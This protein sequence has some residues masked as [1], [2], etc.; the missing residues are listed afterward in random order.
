MVSK[1]IDIT[2][3]SAVSS[4]DTERLQPQP[5]VDSFLETL[6]KILA[7]DSQ[8]KA[9]ATAFDAG[10]K[11]VQIPENRQL[12]LVTTEVV[13][14]K[15]TTLMGS[16][17]NETP[18]IPDQ[19]DLFAEEFGGFLAQIGEIYKANSE[20]YNEP[21]PP[22]VGHAIVLE[23]LFCFYVSGQTL[24][25]NTYRSFAVMYGDCS[26]TVEK[27]FELK[28][29][30]VLTAQSLKHCAEVASMVDRTVSKFS[31][32]AVALHAVLFVLNQF[33]AHLRKSLDQGLLGARDCT[34]QCDIVTNTVYNLFSMSVKTLVESETAVIQQGLKVTQNPQDDALISCRDGSSVHGIREKEDKPMNVL[35]VLHIKNDAMDL[36]DSVETDPP[37]GTLKILH[38]PWHMWTHAPHLICQRRPS[39]VL[40][41]IVL[42]E[43]RTTDLS[44]LTESGSTSI[45]PA[46]DLRVDNATASSSKANRTVCA[47]PGTLL[48]AGEKP[49]GC[50]HK[51]TSTSKATQLAP[52]IVCITELLKLEK[53]VAPTASAT[54]D[55][56]AMNEPNSS[57][58]TPMILTESEYTTGC[59][60]GPQNQQE[61]RKKRRIKDCRLR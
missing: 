54:D 30:D 33:P 40:Q 20:I 2:T 7:V 23:R 31:K 41:K 57:A 1:N 10:V 24:F 9:T 52:N 34:A 36:N 49:D 22:T 5:T 37:T 58:T 39:S 55:V 32:D 3:P 44:K 12:M 29:Q 25:E 43:I 42:C 60:L 46:R 38:Y 53:P 56:E 61:I 4:E 6:C 45:E 17:L 13:L 50:M 19:H 14:A 48:S 8:I 27:E 21:A 28:L 26:S 51:H 16:R 59:T 35:D 11:H 15:I 18:I 47:G